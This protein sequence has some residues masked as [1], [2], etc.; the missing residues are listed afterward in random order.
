MKK[1]IVIN[2]LIIT[3]IGGLI[4]GCSN[5][6]ETETGGTTDYAAK[7]YELAQSYGVKVEINDPSKFALKDL[8]E[9]EKEIQTLVHFFPVTYTYTEDKGDSIIIGSKQSSFSRIK[10]RAKESVS[11][12]YEGM[13]LTV[14]I[15][16]KKNGDYEISSID[17]AT[18]SVSNIYYDI[19]STDEKISFSGTFTL[20]TN[21]HFK[22][23]YTGYYNLKDKDGS[24]TFSQINF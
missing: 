2:I 7:A 4:Y 6:L 3:F 15:K 8:M 5:N 10:T 16:Q 1:I 9:L 22:I 12:S 19:N 14:Y 17:A 11:G 20:Q 23:S 24:V 13:T 21:A 18:G